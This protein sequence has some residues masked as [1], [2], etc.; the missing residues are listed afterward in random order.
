MER[1]TA[2]NTSQEVARLKKEH[3]EL[4]LRLAELNKRHYLSPQEEV[5]RKTLQ[6]LKLAKKD[7]LAQLG[8][9]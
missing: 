7:R 3:R 1:N 9:A 6:K 4:E 2:V 5:E 8:Q